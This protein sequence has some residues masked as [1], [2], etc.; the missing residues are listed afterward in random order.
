MKV[1]LY[2]FVGIYSRGLETLAHILMVGS[3]FATANQIA[4]DEMLEWRLAEDMFP[5]WRQAQIVCNFAQQW[6]ARAAGLPVP[7]AHEGKPELTTVIS[8]IRDAQTYLGRLQPEQFAD[9]DDVSLTLDIG[10]MQP[11]MPLGQ[12][13]IGFATTNFY[14]HSA[15]AYSILRSR[16]V[17]LGKRD[18]FAG[19]L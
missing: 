8:S 2:S 12:W 16:G 11:T 14:F 6:P 1:D 19:G 3:D 18:F 9:R 13:I 5:L 15:V 17:A 4:A 10:V 7:D